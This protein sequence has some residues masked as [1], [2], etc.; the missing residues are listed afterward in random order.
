MKRT[1]FLFLTLGTLFL[2]GAAQPGRGAEL[3][4][5]QLV[6]TWKLLS[7]ETVRPSGEV[8]YEWMGRNPVG[9]IIYDPTGHMS[10][11][12]MHDPRPTFASG[13]YRTA[14]PEEIKTA[15]A[16]YYAY[17]GTYEVNE[18]EGTVIHHIQASLWPGEV[19][20]DYKRQVNL[21]GDRVILTTPPRE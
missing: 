9:L 6:G 15:Y 16:G 17:F 4:R 18:K 14:T 3:D 21:S 7:I 20:I 1:R 11:Q 19:G 2:L 12:I 5:S 10:V 13:E 8:V